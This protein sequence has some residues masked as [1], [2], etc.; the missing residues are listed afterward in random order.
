MENKE[1][2][3]FSNISEHI[4]IVSNMKQKPSKSETLYKEIP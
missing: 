1:I 2:K 4:F 3:E